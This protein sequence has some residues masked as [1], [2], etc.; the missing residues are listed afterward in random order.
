MSH[1]SF[2]L[3]ISHTWTCAERKVGV[4]VLELS[5]DLSASAGS[6]DFVDDSLFQNNCFEISSSFNVIVVHIVTLDSMMVSL[7][8]YL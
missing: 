3:R 7:S 4:G 8:T 1:S 2:R 6:I 5:Q